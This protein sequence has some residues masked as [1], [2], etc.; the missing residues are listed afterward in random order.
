MKERFPQ[1]FDKLVVE[2]FDIY[3]NFEIYCKHVIINGWR[4]DRSHIDFLAIIS[5]RSCISK[6]DDTLNS[7]I[8]LYNSLIV[9]IK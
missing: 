9:Y 5:A 2:Q 1:I 4:D 3:T 6:Y 8:N 7:T